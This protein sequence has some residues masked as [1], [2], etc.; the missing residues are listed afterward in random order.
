MGSTNTSLMKKQ[1]LKLKCSSR[2]HLKVILL[3]ILRKKFSFVQLSLINISTY[4]VPGMDFHDLLEIPPG[5]RRRY[6]DDISIIIISLEG[7][8]WRSCMQTR[9]QSINKS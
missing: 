5:D 6:H 2:Q 4:V 9:A 3:N 1:L 7:R 8:I